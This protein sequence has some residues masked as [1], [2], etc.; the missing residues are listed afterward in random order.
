MDSVPYIEK[1]TGEVWEAKRF[2]DFVLARPLDPKKFS[3]MKNMSNADFDAAF[4]E[5][6]KTDGNV[7]RFPIERTV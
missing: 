4:I 7:I 5:Y 3:K 6:W 2:P 1:K